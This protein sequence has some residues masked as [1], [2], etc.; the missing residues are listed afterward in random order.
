MTSSPNDLTDR[1][2]ARLK[3]ERRKT[4]ELTAS[5]LARP[6]KNSRRAV[7]NALLTIG[8][9]TGEATGRMRELLPRAWLRPLIVGVGL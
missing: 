2:R 4:G 6:A 8:R 9:D 3:G 7:R 1:M 5:E